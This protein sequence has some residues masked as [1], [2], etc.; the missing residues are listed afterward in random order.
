MTSV[1]DII[2]VFSN[3]DYEE[4]L[5][6]KV[7]EA[8]LAEIIETLAGKKMSLNVRGQKLPIKEVVASIFG[9]A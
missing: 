2:R 9:E 8:E 1:D 7:S 3:P 4:D 6:G 5:K